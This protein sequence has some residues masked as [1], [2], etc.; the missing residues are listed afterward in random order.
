MGHC[1]AAIEEDG[2]SNHKE[3][4]RN[5]DN[6]KANGVHTQIIGF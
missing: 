6:N 2:G 1:L 3:P 5:V 4:A